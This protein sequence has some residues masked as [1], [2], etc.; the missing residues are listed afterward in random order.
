MGGSLPTPHS[1]FLYSSEDAY[2]A[3]VTDF[4]RNGVERDERTLMI[5][6][7]E[8]WRNISA[9]L[10]QAGIDTR[11]AEQRGTLTMLEA[12][13]LL[14]RA[15]VDGIFDSARYAAALRSELGDRFPPE[16]LLG[17]A[18]GMLVARGNLAGA[19][20]LE[21]LCTEF[22]SDRTMR[23]FCS[24][25]V[26]HFSEPDHDWQIRSVINAH[27][28][29]I[30]ETGAGGGLVPPSRQRRT[31]GEAE[32]ILLW[33]DHNDTR[34]MYAEAL[35]FS[36]FRVMTAG[37]AAEARALGEA[38]SPDL[39]VL[40]VRLSSSGATTTL[41][42]LKHASRAP[43]PVL[44]LTAHAFTGERDRIAKEG[45]DAV[46]SKPC[47]PDALVAAVSDALQRRPV[48]VKH[49]PPS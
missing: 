48:P 30:I 2:T 41:R 46:L 44:A 49:L 12:A 8:R 16:R 35:T 32:L 31:T 9:R 34:I 4:V 22:A 11:I 5:S 24:H 26:L 13:A 40:D 7:P 21:H 10:G 29:A 6:T 27:D 15:I 45:F 28:Q 36:G 3:A 25:Q 33:D 18:A 47:L 42:T 39:I 23:I 43:A 19:L 14:E 17:D 1:A 20:A 38:Y 37:D